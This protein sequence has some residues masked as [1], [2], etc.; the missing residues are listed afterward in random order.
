[1]IAEI[2]GGALIGGAAALLWLANGRI[3]GMTGVVSSCFGWIYEGSRQRLW[4]VFF[5]V[6][7]VLANPVLQALGFQPDPIEITASHWLVIAAGLLVGIGTYLGNGC[8]SGH[9]VCGMGRLSVRSIMATMVFMAAGIVTVTVM[10]VL[11]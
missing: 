11:L 8:T 9:G 5:L 1:M 3:S 4:A 2:L 10:E 7:L 6:G